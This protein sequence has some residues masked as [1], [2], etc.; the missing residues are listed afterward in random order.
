MWQGSWI[1]I[2]QWACQLP[3]P[4]CTK[5]F[6]S[7]SFSEGNICLTGRRSSINKEGLQ[8]LRGIKNGV[9]KKV[10]TNYPSAHNSIFFYHLVIMIVLR[11]ILS[12][13]H[14]RSNR[15]SVLGLEKLIYLSFNIFHF[16]F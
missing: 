14:P 9:K 5:S 8:K 10:V 7:E 11:M 3:K 4:S 15:F 12:H 1:Y 13:T 2:N 16:L 6:C